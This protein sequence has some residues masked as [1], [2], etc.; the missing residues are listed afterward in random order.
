S[1]CGN[2]VVLPYYAGIIG[3]RQP[4]GNIAVAYTCA[5]Q[6][7]Q[8]MKSL[9]LFQSQEQRRGFSNHNRKGGNLTRTQLIECDFR[10]VID[11]RRFWFEKIEEPGC[12]DCRGAPAQVDIHLLICE[13]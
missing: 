11:Q 10:A 9:V 2:G 12:R 3:C 6:N 1:Y 7:I 8:K 5:D 4:S 13:R